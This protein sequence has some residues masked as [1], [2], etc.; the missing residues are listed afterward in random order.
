MADD[1][2]PTLTRLQI[3]L[4]R[5]RLAAFTALEAGASRHQ[6]EA[7]LAEAK[8]ILDRRGGPTP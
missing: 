6:V 3:A 1:E 7:E 4:T 2:E 5:V 8:R